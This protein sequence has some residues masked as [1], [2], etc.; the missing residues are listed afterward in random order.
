MGHNFGYWN[1]DWAKAIRAKIGCVFYMYWQA[2]KD[3]MYIVP[4]Q[5]GETIRENNNNSEPTNDTKL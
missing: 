4:A 1:I 3:Y 2:H 5:Y